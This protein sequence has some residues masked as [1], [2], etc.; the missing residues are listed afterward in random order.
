MV[1]ALGLLAIPVLLGI[2]AF[3]CKL[4]SIDELHFDGY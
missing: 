4:G 1:I 2:A 3:A